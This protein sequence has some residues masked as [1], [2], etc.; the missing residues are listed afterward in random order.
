[1]LFWLTPRLPLRWAPL[2]FYAVSYLFFEKLSRDTPG[3][4]FHLHHLYIGWL[5]ASWVRAC[6]GLWGPQVAAPAVGVRA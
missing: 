4:A 5:L 1:M 6:C 2:L 3:S